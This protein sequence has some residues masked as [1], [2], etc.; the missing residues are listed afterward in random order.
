MSNVP[1]RTQ[2]MIVVIANN[3][4]VFN[5]PACFCI[6]FILS[7]KYVFASLSIAPS[8]SSSSEY[9]LK[10]PIISRSGKPRFAFFNANP[11]FNPIC[12]YF[13]AAF[14]LYA[15]YLEPLSRKTSI[16]F[17]NGV[18]ALTIADND[19]SQLTPVNILNKLQGG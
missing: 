10:S 11:K 16:A 2:P 4:I 17:V 7:S 14:K 12:I 3:A 6:F 18:P 15:R 19:I 9:I 1:I 8:K 13:N 5:N